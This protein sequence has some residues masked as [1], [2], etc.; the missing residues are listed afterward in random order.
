MVLD[1]VVPDAGAEIRCFTKVIDA[2]MNADGRQRVWYSYPNRGRILLYQ[3][4]SLY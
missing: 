3:S 4:E 2:D 1:E